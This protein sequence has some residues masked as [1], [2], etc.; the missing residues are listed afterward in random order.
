MILDNPF[1][2]L[3]LTANEDPEK[4]ERDLVALVPKTGWIDF[5]HRLILHGRAVCTARSPKCGV[6]PLNDVCPSAD[7]AASAS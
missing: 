1:R 6:C 7:L 2:R 3:G 5:A 4:V